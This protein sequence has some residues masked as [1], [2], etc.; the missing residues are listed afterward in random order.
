[1]AS[2][3]PLH[4]PVDHTPRECTDVVVGGDE[5]ADVLQTLTSETAQEILGVLGDEPGTVSD[6]ADAVDT[7]L[8]NAQY[9]LERLSEADLIESVDTWYS[10]KGKEM[11]VYALTAE[12]LVIQFGCEGQQSSHQSPEVAR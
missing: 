10:T 6:I 5:P 1:M 8:Q 12:E 3:L 11:T 7:S 4:S 9:H 2:A